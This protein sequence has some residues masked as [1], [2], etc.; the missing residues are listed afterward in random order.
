MRGVII[1]SMNVTLYNTTDDNAVVSKTL[2]DAA[3]LSVIQPTSIM[4]LDAPVIDVAYNAAAI[5][6]NYAKLTIT[7]GSPASDTYAAYYYITSRE[8]EPGAKVTLHL[9]IDVL[10]TYAAD[11]R[12]CTANVIRSESAGINYVTDTKLP[13]N[14]S[15]FALYTMPLKTGVFPAAETG[16]NFVVGVN[17]S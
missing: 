9:Q 2:T 12:K 7:E 16:N 6:R 3:A 1:L 10:M 17:A 15:Q 14:P 4:I 11:I 13:L 5:T 8:V